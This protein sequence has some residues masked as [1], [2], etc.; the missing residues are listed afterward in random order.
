[1][2]SRACFDKSCS[3]DAIG[4]ENDKK[5]KSMLLV[6]LL[7]VS[8]GQT[9]NSPVSSDRRSD[10]SKLVL[11]TFNL[12]WCFDG[13]SDPSGSPWTST[14]A[15]QHIQKVAEQILRAGVDVLA[16]HELENCG[17]LTTFLG[18]LG[19]SYRGFLIPGTDTGTRQN[20]ALVSK[21]DPEGP[22]TRTEARVSYPVSGSTCTGSATPS[23]SGVSK[24]GIATIKASTFTFD[25]VFAHFKSGGLASDCMQREAQASVLASNAVRSGVA[26]VLAG[27]FND[28]DTAFTDAD[29]NTGTSQTVPILKG[30][31][32][33]NA[34]QRL[35]LSNRS[36][37]G[38]GLIGERNRKSFCVLLF[39]DC[40]V[41]RPYLADFG[42]Q[43]ARD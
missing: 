20:C 23:D 24:H 41:P 19:S 25:F 34:G 22:L 17:V 31:R 4:W 42:A 21:I 35:P 33:V 26:T 43:F 27:D 36:T 30:S 1:M 10:K 16:V 39:A 32:F 37:S 9:C 7:A 29:G 14:T 15:P 6:L 18:Y 40:I 28:W 2:T 3:G 8:A 12:A 38:V 11:G 13:V 5:T